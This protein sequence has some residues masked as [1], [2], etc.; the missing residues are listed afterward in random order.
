MVAYNENI[1]KSDNLQETNQV[2]IQQVRKILRP[3]KFGKKVKTESGNR[4]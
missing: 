2:K 4:K 3:V 1:V